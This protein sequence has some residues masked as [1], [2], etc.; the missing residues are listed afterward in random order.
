MLGWPSISAVRELFMESKEKKT[1]RLGWLAIAGMVAVCAIW[2]YYMYRPRSGE[3]V[4]VI[5]VDGQEFR[6]IALADAGDGIFSIEQ[7]TGKPV[8]FEISGNA[9][10]FVNV[11]CPDHVCEKAGWCA[12]PGQ[13]AVCMPNRVTLVCYDVTEVPA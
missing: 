12:S 5:S 7:E 2:A 10:R 3:A 6:R 8:S 1:S 11:D 9:I 13:R 4:A